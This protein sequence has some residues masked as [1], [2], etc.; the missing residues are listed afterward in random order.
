MTD[1]MPQVLRSLSLPGE[2]T[3]LSEML[4]AITEELERTITFYNSSHLENPLDSTV[5]VLVSGDL[6][7]APDTWQALAGNAGYSVSILPSPI[8]F[9][10]GFD[11]SQFMVNIGLALKELLSEKEANFSLVN[12][13]TMPGV[14][15]PKA[16]HLGRTLIPIAVAVVGAGLTFY[17]YTLLQ[18][19]M[20]QT[21]ALRAQLP[22]VQSQVAEYQKEIATLKE[23]I[24]QLEPRVAPL[25]EIGRASCRERV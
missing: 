1:R 13:N 4:P 23:Q 15:L 16:R 2:A 9:P 8:G 10:E 24:V 12:L 7:E 14:Y 6:A 17:A 25:E 5:P 22:P 20:A 3:S 18:G 21:S 11:P 19:S